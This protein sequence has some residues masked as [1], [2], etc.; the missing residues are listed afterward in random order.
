MCVN[1]Y[2]IR[3]A[4]LKRRQASE[5]NGRD[6][7][8]LTG[9]RDL[10]RPVIIFFLGFLAVCLFRS[11]SLVLDSRLEAKGKERSLAGIH[12]AEHRLLDAYARASF[13]C[14]FASLPSFRIRLRCCAAALYCPVAWLPPRRD[15]RLLYYSILFFFFGW[16]ACWLLSAILF[17]SACEGDCDLF[18]IRPLPSFSL[19]QFNLF[20]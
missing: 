2:V 13:L 6:G 7:Q 1:A 9:G 15:L 4:C 18:G 16:W 11:P 10:H 12:L 8:R 5:P 20:D 14:L 19:V 17:C 3:D